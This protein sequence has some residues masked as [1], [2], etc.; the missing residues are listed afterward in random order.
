MWS[1]T[2]P[3]TIGED[4][5]KFTVCEIS[6][7]TV[8]CYQTVTDPDGRVSQRCLRDHG[9]Q[10]LTVSGLLGCAK[11][12]REDARCFSFNLWQD[13]GEEQ[14]CQLNDV[15]RL[16]A[17]RADFEATDNCYFFDL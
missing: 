12:C 13:G 16:G 2:V 6:A 1:S 3:C 10:N 14:T 17:D 4:R 9:L 7:S 15:G 11:A 5:Y 8:P